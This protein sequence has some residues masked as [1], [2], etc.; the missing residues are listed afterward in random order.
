MELHT[1]IE[2]TIEPLDTIRVLLDYFHTC[3]SALSISP[4]VLVYHLENNFL[5]HVWMPHFKHPHVNPYTRHYYTFS[6]YSVSG[7]VKAEIL[8]SPLLPI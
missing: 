1:L 2:L 8:M 7:L 5:C 6:T 3:N 4:E